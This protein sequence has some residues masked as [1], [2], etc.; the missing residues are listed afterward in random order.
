MAKKRKGLKTAMTVVLGV[1]WLVL[2]VFTVFTLILTLGLA[3]ARHPAFDASDALISYSQA[4]APEGTYYVDILAKIDSSIDGYTEFHTVPQELEDADGE[5]QYNSLPIDSTS[6]IVQYNEDG[7]VSLLSHLVCAKMVIEK[8]STKLSLDENNEESVIYYFDELNEQYG[9]LR[10]AYVDKN[11]NVLG[12]TEVFTKAY[13]PDEPY[14]LSALGNTLEFRLAEQQPNKE[15]NII[16]YLGIIVAPILFV[17]IT[18]YGIV[19]LIVR[20]V[21]KLR[22]RKQIQAK[23]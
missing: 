13:D 11:G 23:E 15:L 10:A 12:I 20:F 1:L 6:E 19:M 22:R 8:K 14:M 5:P 18:I 16:G 4:N 7:Y 17:L 3:G 21:R 9:D 2:P